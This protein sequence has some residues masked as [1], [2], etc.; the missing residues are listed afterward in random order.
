M[1]SPLLRRNIIAERMWIMDMKAL[2]AEIGKKKRALTPEQIAGCSARLAERLYE[3][4]RASCR[5]RVS[6]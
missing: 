2:R 5:E 3:I 1:T 4:G 6:A